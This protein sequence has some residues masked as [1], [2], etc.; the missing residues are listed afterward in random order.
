[1]DALRWQD[2]LQDPYF[3][4][5]R[6]HAEVMGFLKPALIESQ[7]FPALQGDTG[8]MSASVVTSA[9]FVSDTPKDIKDKINKCVA[10]H[11]T[12]SYRIRSVAGPPHDGYTR[13]SHLP[14]RLP[15]VRVDGSRAS[16]TPAGGAALILAWCVVALT[17]MLSDVR[18]LVHPSTSRHV[19]APLHA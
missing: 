18:P 9:I 4:L 6:D 5:T 17:R 7:F 11:V 3:R 10:P 12:T 15:P 14:Q 16:I 19:P 1:M 2:A 8:K 13:A